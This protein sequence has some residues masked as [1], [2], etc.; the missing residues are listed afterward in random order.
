MCLHC[1]R[2]TGARSAQG[3]GAVADTGPSWHLSREGDLGQLRE[4]V[5]HRSLYHLKEGDPQSW[6]VPRLQGQAKASFV[7][8]QHDE[9]GGGRGECMHAALFVEMMR[10]LDL[11][12]TY[13][14]HLHG[15]PAVT[16][17][18]VNLMSMA[19]LHRSLRGV[20]VGQFA[21]V[22]VTSSPGS[23]RLLAA[24]ARLGAGSAGQRS[25]DEHV[26]ADAVTSRCCAAGCSPTCW[27]A[28]ESR[29]Q[30][31]LRVDCASH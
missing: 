7:T 28:I 13:S 21:M 30:T 8:V 22:E 17:A 2:A 14:A 12:A 15:A 11:D 23:R 16:L 3:R 19:G 18:P 24:F 29:R 4:Y 6:V 26:E 9:Y 27:P 1:P 5:A 10:E 25:Y 20:S 31:P